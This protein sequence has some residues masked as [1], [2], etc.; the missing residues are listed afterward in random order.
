MLVSN[1][2]TADGVYSIDSEVTTDWAPGRQVYKHLHHERLIDMNKFT[3][4]YRLVQIRLISM[5]N[6]CDLFISYIIWK[7]DGMGWTIT[8]KISDDFDLSDKAS[9][10]KVLRILCFITLRILRHF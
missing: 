8:P 9:M 3:I 1:A 2:G 10:S 5:Y 7:P 4:H 6:C